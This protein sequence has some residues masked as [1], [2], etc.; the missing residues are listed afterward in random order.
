MDYFY[1]EIKL[2]NTIRCN[3]LLLSPGCSPA[4]GK[5]QLWVNYLFDCSTVE[6]VTEPQP[7]PGRWTQD[8]DLGGVGKG[9]RH[10]NAF[11]VSLD[12]KK[13]MGPPSCVAYSA[14]T[15]LPSQLPPT[16]HL[17][18]ITTINKNLPAQHNIYLH[19]VKRKSNWTHPISHSSGFIFSRA[20][21]SQIITD[22]RFE[23]TWWF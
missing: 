11:L 6:K 3:K 2:C 23:P 13:Q 12:C 1:F 15:Q 14:E 20:I 8:E 4:T 5:F 10:T 7:K 16:S 18:L 9:G 21:K 22:S 17:L 19:S